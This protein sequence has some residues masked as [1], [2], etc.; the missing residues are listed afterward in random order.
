MKPL[1]LRGGRL[2]DPAQ[3]IDRSADLLLIDGRVAELGTDLAASDP[4]HE[5]DL[6]GLVVVPGLIDVQVRLG[7]PGLV[8]RETIATGSDAAA[9]GGF[10]TVICMPC[11]RPAID[12]AS[13]VAL[14]RDRVAESSPIRV[15]IAGAVTRGMAGEDLASIGSLAAAG[16]VALSDSGH[17][18]QNHQIMRRALEYARMFGLPVLGHCR[19]DSLTAGGVMHEGYWSMVLGLPGWPASA[20]ELMVARNIRLAELTGTHVHC[21]NLC[22]AGSVRLLR[23]ARLRGL[24]V[25]GGTCP[26]YLVLTDAALAGSEA[27][28]GSDGGD[29]SACHPAPPAWPSYDTR[30]KTSPPLR[31]AAD[32]AAL[33]EGLADGTLGMIYSDHAPHCDY[34]KEVEF[35]CAPFGIAGLETSLALSLMALHHPGHLSLADLIHRMSVAPSR[36]LDLGRG[37]LAPG[38]PA[39]VTVLD[40]DHRWVFGESRSKDRNSPFHDWNLRGACMMTIVEGEIVW[41]HAALQ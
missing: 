34:E 21:L 9:R 19:D 35:D 22:A 7:E 2:V 29:W 41:R 32:R 3:G 40:P 23:E 26:H 13:T 20:E 11:T 17:C 16:V 1:L 5:V 31:S 33:I 27:F 30:F 12:T 24:P 10:T 36:L 8:A 28:L 6:G 14:I 15:E 39:D 4:V 18:T 37:N 38:S 25:S